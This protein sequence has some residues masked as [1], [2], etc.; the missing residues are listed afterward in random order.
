MKYKTLKLAFL[1]HK[2]ST[3]KGHDCGSGEDTEY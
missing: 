2:S 1:L 3:S